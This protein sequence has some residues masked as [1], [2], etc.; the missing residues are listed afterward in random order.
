M[1][2]LQPLRWKFVHRGAVAAYDFSAASFTADSTFHSLD[3][4]AIVP[5][6]AKRVRVS[7]QAAFTGAGKVFAIGE[8]GVS[9]VY[10]MQALRC[11]VAGA[12]DNGF[13]EVNIGTDGLIDYYVGGADATQLYLTIIGWWI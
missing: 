9:S 2:I 4:S 11:P 12:A 5:K 1:L 8:H 13:G 7:L 3:V 10:N 6:N